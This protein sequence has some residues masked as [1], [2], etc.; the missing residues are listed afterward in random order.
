MTE[1]VKAAA[2]IALV[3]AIYLI[4]GAYSLGR[5]HGISD[6]FDSVV[7]HLEERIAQLETTCIGTALIA[8][9]EG[10][11]ILGEAQCSRP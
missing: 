5:S 9:A 4:A 1:A 8:D 6:T 10:T 7:A 11:T 3:T 2:L